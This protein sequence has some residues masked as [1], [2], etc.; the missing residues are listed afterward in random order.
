MN[1]RD[2]AELD[3]GKCEALA[4]RCLQWTFARQFEGE[5]L[6]E[7]VFA[8]AEGI[9]ENRVLS[10]RV[11]LFRAGWVHASSLLLTPSG[12][13]ALYNLR[14]ADP[15]VEIADEDAKRYLLLQHVFGS[16]YHSGMLVGDFDDRTVTPER[17]E[18]GRKILDR[19]SRLLWE[20][21]F[22]AGTRQNFSLTNKGRA[23]AGRYL[24]EVLDRQKPQP[25]QLSS[26]W[27]DRAT[28]GQQFV[29]WAWNQHRGDLNK[30]VNAHAYAVT[31]NRNRYELTTILD[32]CSE[33]D[34]LKPYSS[35]DNRLQHYAL[36][37][38]IKVCWDS[39]V[40]PGCPLA[41]YVYF[42]P[43][44]EQVG[45]QL[46][47]NERLVTKATR[48]FHTF[49]NNETVAGILSGV[50]GIVGGFFIGRA[51]APDAKPSRDQAT[52]AAQTQP[53]SSPATLPASAAVHF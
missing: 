31:H 51:T 42:T 28:E 41:Q 22:V 8:K 20:N 47:Q 25:E 38:H 37:T 34:L 2:A 27:K 40:V 43:E 19:V 24:Q 52:P 32:W 11:D 17:G 30:P 46:A 50:V 33:Q 23:V 12:T 4:Q 18:E 13:R 16:N 29:V 1:E 53:A 39:P 49:S 44:G 48:H 15:P 9:S 21:G 14:E 6:T 5:P 10:V 35:R 45:A 7:E 36:N 26:E 3:Y